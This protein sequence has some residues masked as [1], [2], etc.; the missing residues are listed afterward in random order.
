MGRSTIS[1]YKKTVWKSF[2]RY[3]KVRDCSPFG[4]CLCCTC[5]KQL[6]WDDAQLHAGHFLAGRGNAVLFDEVIV[7]SQCSG[8]NKYGGGKPWEYEEFMRRKY[9]YSWDELE[10]IKLRRHQVK[11][12][13]MEELKELKKHYEVEF[14]RIKKEKGL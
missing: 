1:S 5:S 12:Y 11:K 8:C 7:H 6:R 14:N 4:N 2:A 10:E 3:I 13:T 9:G